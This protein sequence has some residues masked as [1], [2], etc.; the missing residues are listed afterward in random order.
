MAWTDQC[1]IDAQKQVEHVS[2][3]EHLSQRQAIQRMARESGIPASTLEK[4]CYAKN[5]VSKPEKKLPNQKK[6]KKCA[7]SDLKKLIQTGKTFRTIYADPPWPYQNQ[8]TRGSTRN[9]YKT[10]KTSMDEIAALPVRDLAAKKAHL[11]LWTTN[12]FL[13]EAAK[14]IQ[15]WGFKYKG[16]FVWVKP[17]MGIGNYWRV[18]HEFLLLGVR[19]GLTFLDTSFKSWIEAK[20][21]KH[22]AKPSRIRQI[23][24]A[25][26]PGP[27]LELYGRELH[28]GWTVWG[29]EIE[30]RVFSRARQ[31]KAS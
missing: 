6:F 10:W 29:D 9:H 27:R 13:F 18:S 8:G 5:G 15:A 20:R 12:A 14:I 4:W 31:L 16:C 1:R 7:V 26:S 19:G 17:Q 24:E 28:D 23:I 21:G 2:K 11:H 22:S 30:R 25:V 3:R